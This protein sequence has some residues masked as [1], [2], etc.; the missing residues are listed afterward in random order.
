MDQKHRDVL[1]QMRQNIIDDLDVYNG[2]IM[3][4]TSEYILKEEDVTDIK[5]GRTK[6]ERAQ[7]LLDLL[8]K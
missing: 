2:V 8:P 5:R 4:L 3:P 6:E 1:V 7:I